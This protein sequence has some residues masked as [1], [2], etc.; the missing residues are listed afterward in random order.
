[1]S[2]HRTARY[3][4]GSYL[5][6]CDRSGRVDWNE[7][8]RTEWNGLVVHKDYYENRNPQDFIYAVQD[9]RPVSPVRPDTDGDLFRDDVTAGE[10]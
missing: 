3:R 8:F 9:Q 2:K 10:L 5:L 4:S 7:N 1:M 6:I